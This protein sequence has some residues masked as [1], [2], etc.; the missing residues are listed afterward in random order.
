MISGVKSITQKYVDA[1]IDFSPTAEIRQT[2]I[3]HLQRDGSVAQFNMPV[4]NGVA[5]LADEVGM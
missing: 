1:L 3:G 2:G 5:Y 4:R